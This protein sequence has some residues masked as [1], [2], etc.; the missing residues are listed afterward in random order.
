[1]YFTI[2]RNSEGKFWWRAV[3]DNNEILAASELMER[4]ASCQDAIEVVKREAASAPVFDKTDD[5]STRG[6][7]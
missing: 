2:R 4:K 6:Q 5:V 3:A 1:V 7:V